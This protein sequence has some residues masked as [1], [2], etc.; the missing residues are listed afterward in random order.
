MSK[1]A[2][3][4]HTFLKFW[5]DVAAKLRDNYDW[6]ICYFV[7]KGRHKEKALELFPHS[8]FHTKAML[9]KCHVPESCKAVVPSPLDKDLLSAM[10]SHESIFLKMMD[11][12]NY[13]GALTY[14][15]R[16]ATYHFQLMY[17]KGVLQHFKPDVIVFSIAPHLGYD[18]V[19][20]GLSRVMRIPT[21]MFER[22]SL[23]GYIYPVTS[24][25][26]RSEL[27]NR[28]YTEALLK[29]RNQKISLT[30]E[31]ASH[32]EDLLKPYDQAMPFHQKYKLNY[33]KLNHYKK[34]GALGGTVPLYLRIA[35]GFLIA[36]LIKK[37]SSRFLRKRYYKN[38]GHL[39]KKK[40]LA[41]YQKMAKAVDLTVP[42]V[43]VALQCEPERQSCPCG[44]AFTHQYVMIDLLSKVIPRE[45]KIY[46]K[47]HPF[48][49]KAYQMAERAKSFEFYDLIASMPNVSLVP[50]TYT[51]FELIDRAKASATVSGSV[52]WESV[53]R[54]KPTFL[55]GHSWYKDC[56]GIF[57]THT[58]EDCKKAIRKIENGYKVNS[59]E[60]K[61]FAQ[62]VANCSV[63]GYIDRVYSKM[64]II[65]PEE[66]VANLAKAI[67]EFTS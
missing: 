29:N 8:V 47:E 36:H 32:L 33:Y 38:I 67:H 12:S 20:Y 41:Y 61:C 15:Q 53:A 63:R 18:Y 9:G 21:V 34:G 28:E 66:N 62:V 49:F 31:V 19:L 54:G 11:K 65:T 24:F 10:S 46:V 56:K 55:F 7:G 26:D 35:A 52:G 48:Q 64:N 6:E 43:F 57:V 25:E 30:P 60:V 45:W 17:W 13:D 39:K 42:Y 23:P 44:G 58:V 59:E 5:I 16:I 3:F 50:L 2:L 14:K 40:L 37:G 1:R 22:T 27:I 4:A 51:S